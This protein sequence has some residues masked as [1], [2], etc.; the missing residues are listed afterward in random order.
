MKVAGEPT[1][2][3][4]VDPRTVA[5]VLEWWSQAKRELPWRE[6]RNPWLILVS[7]VMSQQTQVDRVIPKWTSFIERFPTPLAAAEASAGDLISMWDGLG[8]NRRAVLLHRCAQKVVELHGGE[9]PDDLEHSSPSPA[10]GRIRL[11]RYWRL[12]T[13]AMSPCSTR[14]SVG[15]WRGGPGIASEVERHRAVP[16]ILSR[17]GE[18]GNGI[19]RFSTS[20]RRFVKSGNRGVRTALFERGV[21]GR[22]MDPT[23]RWGRRVSADRSRFLPDQ[24]ERGEGDS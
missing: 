2:V 22:E 12:P 15:C 14:T 6:T 18:A 21:H 8:Y 10:S 3:N 24:I 13:S 19:K 4:V 7:E 20:E 17:R 9:L 5:S 11:G 1:A 23:R 16:T